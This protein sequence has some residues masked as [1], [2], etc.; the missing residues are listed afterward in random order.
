M[1]GANSESAPGV[2]SLCTPM[3][4]RKQ[5]S[6]ESGGSGGSTGKPARVYH[7]QLDSPKLQHLSS[8]SSQQQQTRQQRPL[9][10]SASFRTSTG[11]GGRGD[12]P[13]RQFGGGSFGSDSS[14][15]PKRE[16]KEQRDSLGRVL[17]STDSSP[18]SAGDSGL[19][20]TGS[21]ASQDSRTKTNATTKSSPSS[22]SPSAQLGAI[23]NSS[24][25]TS[26]S[27]TEVANGSS[28]IEA[29]GGPVYDPVPL[30]SNIDYNYYLDSKAQA[31]LLPL[32]QYI[33]EQAKLSGYRFGDSSPI[34]EDGGGGGGGGAGGRS[35]GDHYRSDDEE[36]HDSLRHRL[37]V[38]T[39]LHPPEHDD[40]DDFADDEGKYMKHYLDVI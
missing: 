14:P 35:G 1:S 4:N 37:R 33:L 30:Y 19:A 26:G 5:R 15:S 8:S 32:Q 3:I 40:S 36:E 38:P 16:S 25:P 23:G 29:A 10:S 7:S 18:H 12:Q 20:T 17:R 24:Q 13:Q 28:S 2:D 39:H 22:S 11:S 6:F 9:G 21:R 31:H 27:V 34:A